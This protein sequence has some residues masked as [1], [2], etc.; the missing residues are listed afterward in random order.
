MRLSNILTALCIASSTIALPILSPRDMTVP[1]QAFRR[2]INRMK[3]LDDAMKRI[4]T[5]V[6]DPGEQTVNL[7]ALDWDLMQELRDSSRKIRAIPELTTFEATSLLTTMNQLPTM[8]TSIANGWIQW[9]VMVVA[10][11]KEDD[12]RKQLKD[13]ADALLEF[14]DAM[15]GKVPKAA[16]IQTVGSTWKSALTATID[17]AV[18]SYRKR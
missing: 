8:A 13:D 9:K 2:I 4:R 6:G 18:R 15:N 5:G 7:L 3:P 12:V 14:A 1:E 11:R 10:A 16:L 17:K